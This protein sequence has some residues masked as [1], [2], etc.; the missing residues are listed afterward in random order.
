MQSKLGN[1]NTL[2]ER[3]EQMETGK[4]FKYSG[5]TFGKHKGF[6]N[7]MFSQRVMW[8]E[9]ECIGMETGTL[10]CNMF[11]WVTP[12]V[13]FRIANVLSGIVQMPTT[14]WNLFWHIIRSDW[15]TK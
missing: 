7:S 1:R 8:T 15:V 3:L 11:Q 5:G 12:D 13:C 10:N 14:Y 6:Q 9:E 4:I 2:S